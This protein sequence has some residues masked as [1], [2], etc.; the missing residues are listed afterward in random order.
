MNRYLIY[1]F[2]VFS[3]S[4]LS[5]AQ[6]TKHFIFEINVNR[7]YS[8][9]KN[10]IT[11]YTNGG[12]F[13]GTSYIITNES[14]LISHN[15]NFTL[16]YAVNNNHSIKA[17][18]GRNDMGTRITG[19]QTN[20]ND[21]GSSSFQW[22]RIPILIRTKHYTIA[23]GYTHIFNTDRVTIELGLLWQKHSLE[24]VIFFAPGLSR[25]SWAHSVKIGYHIYIND[26]MHLSP[27]LFLI[28]T[29]NP[30]QPYSPE[31]SQYLP[32]QMGL[33]LGLIIRV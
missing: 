19:I 17:S 32:V 18:I 22:E 30:K 24:D 28:N 21:L 6:E 3:I 5:L 12:S 11:E 10:D 27:K 20:F 13:G 16:G 9:N 33:E 15:Y 7:T 31:E 14:N 4:K 23:Y 26:Q 2:L 25:S 8:F 29:L 1:I